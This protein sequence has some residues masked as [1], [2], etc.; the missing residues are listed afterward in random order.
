MLKQ[1]KENNIYTVLSAIFSSAVFLGYISILGLSSGLLNIIFI[2]VAFIL[3]A[4]SF[5]LSVRIRKVHTGDTWKKSC[6]VLFCIIVIIIGAFILLSLFMG[7]TA[8]VMY[9]LMKDEQDVV[10]IEKV[11]QI[12][13]IVVYLLVIPFIINMLCVGLFMKEEYWGGFK[14]KL[15]FTRYL[16]WLASLFIGLIIGVILCAMPFSG[17]LWLIIQCVLLV[18]AG[19]VLFNVSVFIYNK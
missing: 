11:I 8:V 19:V 13:G 17:V 9:Q 6:I 10:F 4:M 2:S 12:I 5:Y 16:Q 18:V 15:T 14:S 7:L 3:N 1:M